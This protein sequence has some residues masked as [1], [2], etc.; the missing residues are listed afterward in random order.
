MHILFADDSLATRDLYSV[1]LLRAGHTVCFA[2]DGEQA[3]TAVEGE[4]FDAIVLDVRMPAI[5]G[6]EALSCIRQ[7]SNGATVP[8]VLF[9]GMAESSDL[10]RAEAEGATT[11]VAKPALP[12][13]LLAAIERLTAK[14]QSESTGL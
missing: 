7:L 9:S 4:R 1:A 5:S 12:H 10:S 6:W 13:E 8:I 2:H 3:V 11:L 14:Q